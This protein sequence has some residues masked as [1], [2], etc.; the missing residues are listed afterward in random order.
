MFLRLHFSILGNVHAT[1]AEV[2][3]LMAIQSGEAVDTH[4]GTPMSNM[5]LVLVLYVPDQVVDRISAI[6]SRDM[7]CHCL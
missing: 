1:L 2:I 7:R 6:N 4:I 3:L 5:V